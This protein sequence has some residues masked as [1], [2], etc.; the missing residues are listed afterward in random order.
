MRGIDAAA[1]DRADGQQLVRQVSFGDALVA[2]GAFRVVESD[3]AAR[4]EPGLVRQ[5]SARR[6]RFGPVARLC[7]SA[8][9]QDG[10]AGRRGQP[11]AHRAAVDLATTAPDLLPGTRVPAGSEPPNAGTLPTNRARVCGVHGVVGASRSS[12]A[13]VLSRSAGHSRA[14]KPS[15]ARD[16]ESDFR[17]GLLGVRVED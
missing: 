8:M 12:Q 14:G 13:K 1:G 17:T 6:A 7:R 4:K 16:L 15:A 11:V 5:D 2:R 10:W 3:A 9:A